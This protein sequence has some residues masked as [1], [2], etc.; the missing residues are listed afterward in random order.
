MRTNPVRFM[1]N[2]NHRLGQVPKG[3]VF[4][5][6]LPMTQLFSLINMDLLREIVQVSA[7]CITRDAHARDIA[8]RACPTYSPS[9]YI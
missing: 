9:Q 7:T 4:P 2:E 5:T 6:M 3:T 1:L 8:L